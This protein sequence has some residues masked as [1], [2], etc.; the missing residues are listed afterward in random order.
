MFS[1]LLLE[2]SSSPVTD[3]NGL[4]AN[5]VGV[6]PSPADHEQGD[7]KGLFGKLKRFGKKVGRK[8]FGWG[9]KKKKLRRLRKLRFK[10]LKMKKLKPIR[11]KGRLKFRL[12]K[13]KGRKHRGH[14]HGGN[15]HRGHRHRKMG[16]KMIKMGG[17]I[18]R[19]PGRKIKIRVKQKFKIS[20]M[21]SWDWRRYIRG[22]KYECK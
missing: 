5:Q 10:K 3:S 16:S 15:R 20:L 18:I 19:L 4:P 6:N 12:R 8:V 1:S 17:K 21:G 11:L 22:F 14:R 13:Y 7:K 2:N 9:K